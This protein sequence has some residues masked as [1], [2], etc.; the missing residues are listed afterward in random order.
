MY[1]RRASYLSSYVLLLNNRNKRRKKDWS[2]CHLRYL[3]PF[4]F[5]LTYASVIWK[6][7]S[8]HFPDIPVTYGKILVLAPP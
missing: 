1:A 8:V 6:L 4:V 2:L 7:S 5:S 3:S